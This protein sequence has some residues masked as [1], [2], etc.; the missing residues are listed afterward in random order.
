MKNYLFFSRKQIPVTVLDSDDDVADGIDT[1]ISDSFQNACIESSTSIISDTD[2]CDD[3]SDKIETPSS[4]SP[5]PQHTPDVFSQYLH[6]SGSI[7]NEDGKVLSST[8]TYKGQV[9][10]IGHND[11]SQIIT[12]NELESSNLF[13]AHRT[14]RKISDSESD[15]DSGGD[16]NSFGDWKGSQ[17]NTKKTRKMLL[18]QEMKI[19]YDESDDEIINEAIVIS[20]SESEKEAPLRVDE[21][22]TAFL[23]S[24]LK[25]DD[26]Q[27][28]SPTGTSLHHPWNE[29]KTGN[30]SI[31]NLKPSSKEKQSLLSLSAEV[32]TD[33]LGNKS[34]SILE[35]SES[36]VGN[37]SGR[38]FPSF[39]LADL[40]S[41][42]IKQK[43]H[44]K[45]VCN[46]M[47]IF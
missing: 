43:F 17:D 33:S 25:G 7:R 31:E 2:D 44:E 29:K 35:V 18:K 12:T 24:R 27:L 5:V 26:F 37:T 41:T 15:I 30:V 36:S 11:A 8:P 3:T 16:M 39:K 40:T 34:V 28:P 14:P 6:A 19:F 10:E 4:L 46:Y 1:R 21:H 42:E 9:T 23:S 20:D 45:Q 47:W 22:Q 32:S 13:L 38:N